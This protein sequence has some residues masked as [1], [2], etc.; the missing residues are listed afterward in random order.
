MRFDKHLLVLVHNATKSPLACGI[1]TV[2]P[3][4]RAAI[5]MVDVPLARWARLCDAGLVVEGLQQLDGKTVYFDA[6]N[7]ETITASRELSVV[8]HDARRSNERRPR[9][10]VMPP[11]PQV[12]AANLPPAPEP[13]AAE[14]PTD[15]K[16]KGDE[17]KVEVKADEPKGQ[18]G[19][20]QVGPPAPQDKVP[21]DDQAAPA[22]HDAAAMDL[23][24]AK[25][26]DLTVAEL[27]A[28]LSKLGLSDD[29]KKAELVDRLMDHKF[30]A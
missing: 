1:T 24:R 21:G 28:E 4:H 17:P 18:D 13:L 11:L 10:L 8:A 15:D 25:L 27:R 5:P 14:E 23:E 12:A 3:D 6:A 19:L 26:V 30:P 9:A 7:T 29:G 22:K 16:G 20:T 2:L